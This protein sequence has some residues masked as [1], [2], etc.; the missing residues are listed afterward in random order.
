MYNVTHSTYYAQHC[1]GNPDAS[2]SSSSTRLYATPAVYHC[3]LNGNNRGL[4]YNL[5]LYWKDMSLRRCFRS[6]HWERLRLW[7]SRILL[8]GEISS[9]ISLRC[10]R[11]L[12]CSHLVNANSLSLKNLSRGIHLDTYLYMVEV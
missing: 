9:E 2:S 12:Y 10:S 1:G 3:R 4:P 7:C 8:R 5:S 6:M 11:R